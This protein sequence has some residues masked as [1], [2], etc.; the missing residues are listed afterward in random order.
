MARYLVDLINLLVWLLTVLLVVDAVMSFALQP[1]H[2]ARRFFDRLA[3]PLVRPFRNVLPPMGGFDLSLM[4][5]L[6]VIQL[7]GQVLARII[8]QLF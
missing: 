4:A 2:P 8:V 7:V 6:I 3:E 1:W 5:A